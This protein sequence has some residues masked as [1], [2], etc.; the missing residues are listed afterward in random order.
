MLGDQPDPRSTTGQ[1]ARG[2]NIYMGASKSPYAGQITASGVDRFRSAS[3]LP[4]Y[5][6]PSLADVARMYLNGRSQ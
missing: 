6:K 5:K 1:L 3:L 2:A 4:Q